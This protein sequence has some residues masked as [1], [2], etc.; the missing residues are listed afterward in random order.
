MII[1]EHCALFFRDF[2]DIGDISEQLLKWFL[3]LI[4]LEVTVGVMCPF[5]FSN[6]NEL[7]LDKLLFAGGNPKI[8]NL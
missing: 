7:L 3:G 4:I 6:A 1:V 2:A 8:P 5:I